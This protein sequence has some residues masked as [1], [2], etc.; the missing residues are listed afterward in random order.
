MRGRLQRQRPVQTEPNGHAAVRVRLGWAGVDC[1][2]NAGLVTL[3]YSLSIGGGL[4]LT[5]VTFAM[6]I[7]FFKA[8]KA[9]G[10]Q[11]PTQCYRRAQW[12][13]A[14]QYMGSTVAVHTP[15]RVAIATTWMDNG[16]IVAQAASKGG[17]RARTN[18]VM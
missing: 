8:T 15:K 1:S 16:S 14:S 3:I 13:K 5:V 4:V 11:G 17:A 6:V 9:G 7:Y 2:T 12:T 18:P 10:L